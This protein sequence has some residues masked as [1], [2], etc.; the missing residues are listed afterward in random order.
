M[1]KILLFFVA[2]STVIAVNAQNEAE[3][4]CYQKY[5]KVFEKRGAYPVEDG[6]YKDVIISFR[7]GSSAEC[8]YGK[9]TV[10]N[11]AINIDEMY[12]SFEDETYEKIE[13]RYKYADRVITIKNGISETI[14]TKDE[15]LINVLFVS[16]I[17]PPKKAYKKAPDPNFDF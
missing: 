17:K 1:K 15:E 12:L 8:Y 9:V 3:P 7:K 6:E 4:T 2:I 10:K 13:E 16:K 5:A 11:G 14:V